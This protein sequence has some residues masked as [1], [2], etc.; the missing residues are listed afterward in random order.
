MRVGP[1]GW[2]VQ[3]LVQGTWKTRRRVMVSEVLT[4]TF[5]RKTRGLPGD[6]V[7]LM[8]PLEGDCPGAPKSPRVAVERHFE[9]A[10]GLQIGAVTRS[11]R[12]PRYAAIQVRVHQ[13]AGTV[14]VRHHRD[15]C[16]EEGYA[17]LAFGF[18]GCPARWPAQ[19][20]TD[21]PGP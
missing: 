4:E 6:L 2:E 16:D 3:Q 8:I 11:D 9:N 7:G 21:L 14:V 19:V 13:E 12:D 10:H 20:P 17:V 1:Q 15:P 5:D 18:G